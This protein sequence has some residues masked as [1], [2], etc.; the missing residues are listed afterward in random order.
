MFSSNPFRKST[1]WSGKKRNSYNADC[2]QID[3]KETFYEELLRRQFFRS[4]A[5]QRLCKRVDNGPMPH[6][7]ILDIEFI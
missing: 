5:L 7:G 1:H 6:E 2:L 4:L 3:N